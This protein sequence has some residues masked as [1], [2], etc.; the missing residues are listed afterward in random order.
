MKKG[1]KIT[2]GI[3]GAIIVS[4]LAYLMFIKKDSKLYVLKGGS[5][6]GLLDPNTIPELS[7]QSGAEIVPSIAPPPPSIYTVGS[8]FGGATSGNPFTD[9]SEVQAFQQWVIDEMKDPSILGNSGADGIWGNNTSKAYTKYGEDYANQNNPQ[10]EV[11]ENLNQANI[12][13]TM[14]S[15]GSVRV[16][17]TNGSYKYVGRFYKNGRVVFYVDGKSVHISK[18][19]YSNGGKK[20]VIFEGRHN[21]KTFT[22]T[23]LLTNLRNAI[24]PV[25][26][27]TQTQSG[28]V[29]KM[30]KVKGSYTNLRTSSEIDDSGFYKNKIGKIE[31]KG[32]TIGKI[33]AWEK[34]SGYTWYWINNVTATINNLGYSVS[35]RK[36]WVRG[37]T[38]DVV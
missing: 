5:G 24:K 2:L 4:I 31:G 21:G 15:D 38:I 14:A 33:G 10:S 9:N 26:N 22:N 30:A 23:S 16:V 3:V 7:G 19:N 6:G 25:A 18:G 20:I 12:G 34:K 35:Q 36:G 11:V 1:L 13:Y 32:T 29:G 17:Y 27:V 8:F 37:D 28:A